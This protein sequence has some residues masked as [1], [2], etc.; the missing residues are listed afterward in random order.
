MK[1]H[2]NICHNVQSKKTDANKQM[3]LRE[4]LFCDGYPKFNAANKQ[5]IVDR[6]VQVV[7]VVKAQAN[8]SEQMDNAHIE[9]LS[10]C[11]RVKLFAH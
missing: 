6:A 9:E 8:V 4:R 7:E 10:P 11:S 3:R 5:I 2:A 1:Y